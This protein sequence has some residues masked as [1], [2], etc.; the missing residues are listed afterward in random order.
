MQMIVTKLGDGRVMTKVDGSGKGLLEMLVAAN[1]SVASVMMDNEIEPAAILETLEG[2]ANIGL[3][4][5]ITERTGGGSEE[6][7]NG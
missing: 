2:M 7:D 3:E 6:A 4:T 5:A 1:A